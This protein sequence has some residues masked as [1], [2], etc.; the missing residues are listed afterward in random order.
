MEPNRVLVRVSSVHEAVIVEVGRGGRLRD[1]GSVDPKDLVSDRSFDRFYA[2]Q[3]TS[4]QRSLAATL[5]SEDLAT[6]ATAEA[7]ARAFARWGTV[8]TYENPAAWVYRVGLNWS[9]SRWRKR[10]R[11]VLTATDARTRAPMPVAD[12]PGLDRAVDRALASLSMDHRA[13]VVLRFLLDWSEA[14]TAVALGVAPG[15]VKSRT[16][17]ALAQLAELLEESDGP[18]V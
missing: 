6:E 4:I 1:V 16:S 5:R 12:R 18:D 8:S 11:E 10:R 17:R 7:M 13:V 2:S 14:D 15:T 9:T 3:A